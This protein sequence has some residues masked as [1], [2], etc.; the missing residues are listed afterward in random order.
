VLA[1]LQGSFILLDNKAHVIIY[2]LVEL[3]EDRI[4]ATTL[5]L[6][7]RI[8]G[9]R[10]SLVEI[11]KCLAFQRSSHLTSVDAFV[12][13]VVWFL[14]RFEIFDFL[15]VEI[16]KFSSCHECTLVAMVSL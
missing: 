9:T 14:E 1:C 4:H 12:D 16:L 2:L 5:F 7:I 15:K 6:E 10:V 13:V 3:F 8:V 11:R